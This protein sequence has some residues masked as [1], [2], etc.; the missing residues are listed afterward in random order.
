MVKIAINA[1]HYQGTA[2]K[3]IPK[4]IDPAQTREWTLNSRVVERVIEGLKA[5]TGYEVLRIDDP[6]GTKDTS[7]KARTDK[8]NKWGA[9]LYISVHHNAAG[10]GSKTYSASGIVV[11]IYTKVDSYTKALQ[12]TVYDCLI[13][14]TGNK[15]NRASPLAQANLHEVRETKMPSI[16]CE[17]GFMDGVT[18]GNLILTDKYAMQLAQGLVKA[19]AEVGKLQV[20]A[21]PQPTPTPQPVPKKTI[22]DI[23]R[24]VIV[25]KWGNGTTRK[26]ALTAAGYDYDTVQDMVNQ[27]RSGNAPAP[28]PAAPKPL[29]VGD[30]VKIIGSPTYYNTKTKVPLF[31]RLATLYVRQIGVGK[32]LVST[33]KSGAVTGWVAVKDI[34]KA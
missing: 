21:T 6:T 2:G 29:A 31:I 15:G 20:K 7:L 5:Y 3:R 10:S 23:A 8:A 25:G 19:I 11:Y 28:V 9:E 12:K 16:L 1:G 33:L 4:A 32:V 30:R 26:N 22:D 18:D 13:T 27:I 24:E 17:C 34:K 14:A